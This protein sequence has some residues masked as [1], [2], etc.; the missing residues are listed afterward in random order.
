MS[1]KCTHGFLILV[2][3]LARN[4]MVAETGNEVGRLLE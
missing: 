1:A 4:N 2:S 3:L